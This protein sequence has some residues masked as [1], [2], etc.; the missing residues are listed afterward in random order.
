[1]NWRIVCAGIAAL[2]I[3]RCTAAQ[4]DR[5]S[6]YWSNGQRVSVVVAANSVAV[7]FSVEPDPGLIARVGRENGL[8]PNADA[9]IRRSG[10]TA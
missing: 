8:L 9:G 5:N 1:M 10:R 2:G 7:R 6:Y 4:D 3:M